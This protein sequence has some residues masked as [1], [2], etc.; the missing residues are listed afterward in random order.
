[1]RGWLKKCGAVNT[2]LK[3]RWFVLEGTTLSYYASPSDTTPKGSIQVLNASV[4]PV[5]ANPRTLSPGKP[6]LHVQPAGSPR[7][8]VMQAKTFDER[9]IWVTALRKAS[10][11]SVVPEKSMRERRRSSAPDA[12]R[13]SV[14]RPRR[15]VRS[16][17][18]TA[19]AR[20]DRHRRANRAPCRAPPPARPAS[21]SSAA[22]A[23]A[24][25]VRRREGCV[26]TGGE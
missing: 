18:G 26:W 12:P 4:L 23:R 20:Q 25:R 8:Y 17:L 16:R 13:Q 15:R 10:R 5:N 3:R 2:N 6:R 24:A 21:A 9:A 7:V 14:R 11:P 19:R 1:M 22:R